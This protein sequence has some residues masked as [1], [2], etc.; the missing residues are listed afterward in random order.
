MSNTTPHRFDDDAGFGG[1]G[2]EDPVPQRPR[3]PRFTAM[4][5]SGILALIL[6]A[7]ALLLPA[8]YVIFSPGPTFNTIGQSNGGG[9]SGGT[10]PLIEVTG[11]KSYPATGNL[12]LTTVYESGGPNSRISIFS[13][14]QAWLDS[15]RSVLPVDLVYPPGITH[16]QVQQESQQAMASSQESAVAAALMHLGIDY[17]EAMSVAGFSPDSAAKGKLR[18]KDTLLTIDG[19]KVTG[20]E[21]LRAT[22]SAGDGKPV[23]LTV[24]RAGTKTRVRV[25][26]HKSDTGDYLLGVFLS[27]SFDFPFQVSIE[28]NRVGGPSAGMMFAL[29]IIDTLTPG[30]LTGGKHFAGT[31]TIDSA[32]Q[33]GPIGGIAEKMVGARSGGASIFL[34]PAGNCNDV[35]GHIPDG[36]RVVKV[37]TLEDAFHAVKLIG[38]GRDS[39]SLPTCTAG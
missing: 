28:L 6:V 31:G 26:P 25:T 8:P 9:K 34:A 7:A 4:V 12:N 20:I 17:K 39:S 3:D 22:L 2:H 35:V 5:C 29:G 18:K 10:Q 15:S 36:L 21:M 16:A 30:D 27:T 23:A 33:V 13:A 37:S 14:Y 32:G 1:A 11:H 38:S 24:D 19:K